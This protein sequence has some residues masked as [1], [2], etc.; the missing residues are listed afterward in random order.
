MEVSQQAN[1]LLSNE[2]FN[3][4]FDTIESQYLEVWKQTKFSDEVAREKL[5]MQ[6]TALKAVK[7]HIVTYAKE[8][9][10]YL[11]SLEKDAKRR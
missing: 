7:K 9:E 2:L 10:V 5:F 11:K 8:G 6:V 1:N 4:A 3:K